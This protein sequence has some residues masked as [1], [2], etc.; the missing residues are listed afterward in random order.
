L[1]SNSGFAN[2]PQGKVTD[3]KAR[4]FL[5]IENNLLLPAY[6]CLKNYKLDKSWK[7]LI[8]CVDEQLRLRKKVV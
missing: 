3:G 7:T 4:Y 5:I 8:F 1:S 6:L 2:E